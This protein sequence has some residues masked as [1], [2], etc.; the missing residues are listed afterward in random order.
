[1]IELKRAVNTM[2]K[3][4][5]INHNEIE[6]LQGKV[7]YFK[8]KNELMEGEIRNKIEEM[9]SLKEKSWCRVLVEKMSRLEAAFKN[10][11]ETLIIV[12]KEKG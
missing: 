1:M 2:H 12:L 9:S 3:E 10:K 4:I 11:T 8:Y 7:S 6:V 5:I